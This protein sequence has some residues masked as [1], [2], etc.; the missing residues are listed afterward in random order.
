M[1]TL[2]ILIIALILVGGGVVAFQNLSKSSPASD[3]AMEKPVEKGN[4]K[5]FTVEGT[6]FSF[7]PKDIKVKQGDTVKVTFVNKS[8]FH[9]WT[10]DEFKVATKQLGVGQQETV[11]FVASKKGTFGYYCSVGNH[12]AQGMAGKFVVE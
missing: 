5:I 7:F 6:S 12:R 3:T 1:R 9:D 11:E 4:I 8:G 10:L 2:F